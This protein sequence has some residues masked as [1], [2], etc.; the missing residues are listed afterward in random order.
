MAVVAMAV[1]VSA[2]AFVSCGS[3]EVLPS[4]PAAVKAYYEKDN[5][6]A[7]DSDGKISA[8]FDLSDGIVVAY[9]T[10][11]DAHRFLKSL[12]QQLTSGDNCDV[13]K[14]TNNEITQ[15][16]EKQTRLYNIIMEPRSYNTIMAPVEATLDK[17][18]KE[19][20]SAL[21]VTDFEEYTPDRK[22]Q[23]AAFATRYFTE[24]VNQGGDITFFVFDYKERGQKKHLYFIVFDNKEHKLLKD[25]KEQNGYLGGCAEFTLSSGN[26]AVSTD[27]P[28]SVQGGTYHSDE[29]V[30]VVSAVIEDGSEEAYTNYGKGC[31]VEYYPLGDNWENILANSQAMQEPG[32]KPKFTHL[33]KNLFIDCSNK[34][35][36]KLKSLAVKVTNVQ[37]DFDKFY[38]NYC[39]LCATDEFKSNYC[40]MDGNLLPDYAY[41]PAETPLISDFLV[42]DND[43]LAESI[44]ES[45]GKKA[46]IGI[47]FS[48]NFHGA[49]VGANSGDMLRVDV[50]IDEAQP[51]TSLELDE[52]FSWGLQS[53]QNSNLTDAI[54]NTLHQTN[55]KGKVIY[56]YFVKAAE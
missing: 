43:L 53:K 29:N 35:S 5:G 15:L 27:Y 10:N 32:V 3:S 39:Y 2:G 16:E 13:Y 17:I 28:S 40:D 38:A 48:P 11:D 9:K 12:V 25:I 41:N 24:W 42:L 1:I 4:T 26:Y 46:E 14:F 56:T 23:H 18:V 20:K 50:V 21:M 44:E 8:Y 54:R 47:T 7:A 51:N 31:L 34:D 37:A 22:V 30:D 45:K 36:Y 6:P 19:K 55:P 33:L 49:L 52:L